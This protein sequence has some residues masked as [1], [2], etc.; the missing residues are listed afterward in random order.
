MIFSC[1]LPWSYFYVVHKNNEYYNGI[2]LPS[3]RFFLIKEYKEYKTQNTGSIFE[4][5]ENCLFSTLYPHLISS[6]AL[7]SV[8]IFCCHINNEK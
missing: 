1:Y 5:V 6:I 3:L 8:R 7:D 4:S 2:L